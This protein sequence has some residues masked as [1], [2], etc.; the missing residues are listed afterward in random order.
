M[1]ELALH[2]PGEPRKQP[3]SDCRALVLAEGPVAVDTFGGRL[4][5]ECDPTAAVTPLGQLPFF[6]DYLPVSGLFDPWVEQCP[7]QGTGPHAPTKRDVLGT[8]VLSLLGG[9]PR[10]API[11]ALRGEPWRLAPEVTGKPVE[12][13]QQGAGLGD[14]PPQ[15]GRPSHPCH[16]DCSAVDSDRALVPHPLAG[17]G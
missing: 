11:G 10:Y 3:E 1:K 5:V 12:G 14:N 9:H 13:P 4:H 17:T 2:P 15:P 6:T 8:A 16:T 7:V